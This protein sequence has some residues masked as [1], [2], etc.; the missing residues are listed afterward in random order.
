MSVCP[1]RMPGPLATTHILRDAASN[2][3]L[4]FRC[5]S[6]H[7]FGPYL[8]VSG[9]PIGS[10]NQH[11]AT[12]TH[13][14]SVLLYKCPF[15]CETRLVSRITLF[16]F[17]HCARHRIASLGLPDVSLIVIL[18]CIFFYASFVRVLCPRVGPC[19]AQFCCPKSGVDPSG[20]SRSSFGGS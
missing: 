3:L 17:E 12:H 14:S 6:W 7:R 4:D 10:Q 11:A 18:S 9:L 1:N 2:M 13:A 15:F 16:H 8:G 19:G 20:S 5:T